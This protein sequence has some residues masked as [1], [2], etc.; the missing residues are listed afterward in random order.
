MIDERDEG[1]LPKSGS[2]RD[3]FAWHESSIG[4]ANGIACVCYVLCYVVL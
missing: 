4:Y 2:V 3:G 1:G